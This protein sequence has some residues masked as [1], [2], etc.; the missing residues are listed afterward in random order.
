MTVRRRATNPPHRQVPAS[1]A[2][3][4]PRAPKFTVSKFDAV[5]FFKS[6]WALFRQLYDHSLRFND[7][8]KALRLLVRAFSSDLMVEGFTVSNY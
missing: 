4:I 3:S 5:F 6:S 2:G 7:L 1:N 8:G